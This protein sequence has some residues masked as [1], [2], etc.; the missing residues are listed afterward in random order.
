MKKGIYYITI[1]IN[2][3]GIIIGL[4][5]LK[6]IKNELIL[7]PLVILIIFEFASIFLKKRFLSIKF[8]KKLVFF[9]LIILIIFSMMLPLFS[10]IDKINLFI[11]N[12][13]LNILCKIIFAISLLLVLF[14]LFSIIL[15]SRCSKKNN[16]KFTKKVVFIIIFIMSLLF[17]CSTTTGFYD[18]DFVSIWGTGLSNWHTFGFTI[19]THFCKYLFNNPYPI[20][21]LNF[22]LYVYFCY[23][24]LHLIEKHTQ[25]K[26]Y[27]ILFLIIN[28]I[29]IV[30]F[31]QLRYL[32]KDILF[33]LS[34]CII[35]VTF[36]DYFLSEKFTKRVIIHL[37]IFSTLSILFRHGV[38]YLLFII[39]ALFLITLFVK[40]N[41]KNMMYTFLI[42]LIPFTVNSLINYI[43]INKLNAWT[44]KPNIAYTVPIYQ[45]GAFANAGY[46][47]SDSEKE[48]LEQ[49]LPIE[50][51]ATNFQKYN[52]DK[53]SR[54]WYL[55]G[56]IDN[57]NNFNY[58]G[59]LEVNLNLFLEKPIFYI[60]SILDL[61]NIVWKM[62]R[63]DNELYIYFYQYDLTKQDI[64]SFESVIEAKRTKINTIVDSIVAIG[65]RFCLM[66]IRARGGL[67]VF[68][69]I[70][71]MIVLIYKK[72]YRLILPIIFVLI[73]IMLLFLSIPMAITRY[74]LPF[75]NIYP[76]VFCLALGI[77]KV[78]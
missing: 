31:D 35:V 29:T 45:V 30:N 53:L 70:L 73:W 63:D 10:C 37:I 59:L 21:I 22:M 67:S 50:Y 56:Y 69:L 51:M 5:G 75:I 46:T 3:F 74:A 36:F 33:S 20:I 68:M 18:S 24:A 62:E 34:F 7:F 54:D 1:I 61:A 19:L 2:I 9:V 60:R 72:Y 44:I 52:G 38:T 43:C 47:F 16:T 77:K 76:F 15:S 26:F 32:K 11:Y 58:S 66:E 57:M 12:A 71:S 13:I 6:S 42:M 39:Y 41:Y 65:L 64:E 48:Y 23:Y 8:E 4:L 17:I 14:I 78:T 25:N 40:K 27:L 28:L 49:Y 55:T